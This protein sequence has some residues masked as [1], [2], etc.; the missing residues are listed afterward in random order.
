[1]IEQ[2]ER[3]AVGRP[4]TREGISLFPVF[5]HQDDT[6]VLTGDQADIVVTEKDDAE[7]PTLRVT[8]PH[9]LPVLIAEGETLNGGRQ[10][11]VVNVSVLVSAGATIDIPVSC[12]E[13][14]RWG[15]ER[16]FERR[17]PKAP[18]RVRR[19]MTSSVTDNLFSIGSRRSDQGQVWASVDD[20]LHGLGLWSPSSAAAGLV[21]FEQRD[22]KTA[23]AIEELVAKGP[24]PGQ[25]G[26]VISHGR[27]VVA[28]DIYASS[29]LLAAAWENLVRGYFLEVRTAGGGSPSATKVLNFLS[30]MSKR[31]VS[32]QAGVDRG[33]EHR[34]STSKITGQALVDEGLLIHASAFALAA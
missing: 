10:N 31:I 5:V 24:L 30:K 21:E 18:R 32:T 2:L 26:V 4:I 25:C 22:R 13:A 28:A 9:D 17:N 29:S 11:R 23:E 16:A 8:N 6:N 34:I 3:A 14:G 20:E 7:V 1:M 33:M 15:S 12:V 27:R 19:G